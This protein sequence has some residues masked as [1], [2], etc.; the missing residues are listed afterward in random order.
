MCWRKAC[1][2]EPCGRCSAGQA[3]D[4]GDVS[5]FPLVSCG[6]NHQD[7]RQVALC[8]SLVMLG[9]FDRAVKGT[10]EAVLGI[11][12]NNPIAESLLLSSGT[13]AALQ[14]LLVVGC[15]AVPARSKAVTPDLLCFPSRGGAATSISRTTSLRTR[16]GGHDITQHQCTAAEEEEA[17]GQPEGDN[18]FAGEAP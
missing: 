12:L 14:W 7:V 4:P 2:G 13:G 6:G 15:R 10:T 18:G 8:T 5:L 11:F 16:D 3:L 1:S 17:E 9:H